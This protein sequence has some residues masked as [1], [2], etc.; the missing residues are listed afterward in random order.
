MSVKLGNASGGQEMKV[1]A[2]A[3]RWWPGAWGMKVGAVAH[4]WGP[5]CVG[6][7]QDVS[8]RAGGRGLELG[9]CERGGGSDTWVVAGMRGSVPGCV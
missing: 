8:V 9:T 6:G 2:S 4:Q 1:G 7:G 3:H 5:G